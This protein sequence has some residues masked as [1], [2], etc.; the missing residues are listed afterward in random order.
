M[1]PNPQETAGLVTF[2]EEILNYKLHFLCGEFGMSLQILVF[3]SLKSP[4]KASDILSPCFKH[5]VTLEN[6][7]FCYF[8]LIYLAQTQLKAWSTFWMHSKLTIR[9][10]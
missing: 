4:E 2:T 6:A 5:D 8:Y 9:Q 10:N 7:D 3:F 1:W